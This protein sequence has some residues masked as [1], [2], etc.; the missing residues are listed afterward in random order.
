MSYKHITRDKRVELSALLKAGVSQKAIS[1]QLGLHR[2]TVWREIKR[3]EGDTMNY[4]ARIS[5]PMA[6][7]RRKN[8]NAKG[9]RIKND[10]KLKAFII[11]RL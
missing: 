3:N 5:H 4:D 9:D 1:R 6:C 2:T 8:A 10:K 7:R 11:K